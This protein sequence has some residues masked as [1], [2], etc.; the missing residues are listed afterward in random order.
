VH[1]GQALQFSVLAFPK[2]VFT[3]NISYVATS[4][5]PGTRRLL[6]RATINN[7]EGAL[8]PEMFASVTILTGEGDNSPAV[9]RDAIIYDGKDVRVW[10]ALDDHGL[11]SRKIQTGLSNGQMIQVLDG[12]RVGEKVVTKGSLFVDRAAAGS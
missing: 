6:V 4:F 11:E 8:R 9:P 3:A 12:L 1:V 7:S 2:R 10:I 5:D